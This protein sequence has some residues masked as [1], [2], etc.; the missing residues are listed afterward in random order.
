MHSNLRYFEIENQELANLIKSKI[1]GVASY[2][3]TMDA[4]QVL[5]IYLGMFKE[6]QEMQIVK[7][8]IDENFE[9]THIS[10][11]Y[12][13]FPANYL[14]MFANKR[15]SL[16]ASCPDATSFGA[17]GILNSIVGPIYSYS[18]FNTLKRV[19]TL[20]IYEFNK[21]GFTFHS[22]GKCVICNFRNL[23]I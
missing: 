5:P 4:S 1:F 20:S 6:K 23:G 11:G 17:F 19:P 14:K 10:T 16:Y 8:L 13:N 2:T 9:E 22:K 21:S 15:I 12:L 18:F 3:R 7:V